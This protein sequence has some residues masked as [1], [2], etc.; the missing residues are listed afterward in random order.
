MSKRVLLLYREAERVPP[1]RDALIAAG[2]EPEIC[3]AISKPP[4]D[5]TFGGLLLTGGIDLDPELYGER[6]HPEADVPDPALDRA[7]M[8]A[9]GEAL[10]RHAPI[11]AICRGMQVLNVFHGGSLHQHLEP[12]ERHRFIKDGDR[13]LPVHPVTIHDGTLLAQIAGAPSWDVNSRHH[14]AV[15]KL[16]A[17]LKVSAISPEDGVIEA[18]ERTDEGFVLGVQWHPEDQIRRDAP[19]QKLFTHF[20]ARVGR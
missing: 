14:Q 18:I 8:A 17:G 9:I 2:L 1:Y 12:P 7:E 16:G 20:G 6:R 5:D 3:P 11:L 10:E 4:F 13:S 15:K 19:Q